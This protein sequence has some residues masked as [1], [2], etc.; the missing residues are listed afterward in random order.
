MNINLYC[1]IYRE[2][3]YLNDISPFSW[4]VTTNGR[5]F[6]ILCEGRECADPHTHEDL[7]SLSPRECYIELRKIEK[8]DALD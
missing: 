6:T 7:C 4:E 1:E 8:M 2:V 5:T 3:R